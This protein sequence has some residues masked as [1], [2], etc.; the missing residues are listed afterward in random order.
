[1]SGVG[2]TGNNRLHGLLPCTLQKDIGL[3]CHDQS[4]GTCHGPAGLLLEALGPLALQQCPSKSNID[5]AEPRCQMHAH[6]P[7]HRRLP[8]E[9]DKH[10]SKTDEQAGI[11]C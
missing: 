9:Q 4:T 2:A 10:A 11:C 7:Q 8:E 1:M 6:L 3:R 5:A